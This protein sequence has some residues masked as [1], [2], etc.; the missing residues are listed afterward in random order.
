MMTMVVF[1]KT[2]KKKQKKHLNTDFTPKNN[3]KMYRRPKGK[4]QNYSTPRG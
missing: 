3:S 2:K 1:F 4:I